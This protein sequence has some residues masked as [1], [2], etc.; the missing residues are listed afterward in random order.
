LLVPAI[1]ASQFAQPFMVSGVAVALPSLGA[2]LGAGATALSLVETLFLASSVALLLPAGRLGDTADKV[3]IYK[4]GLAGF[5]L[6]SIAVGLVSSVAAVLVLR[7]VQGIFAAAIQATGGAIIADAV[8]PE[9]RGRAYGLVIGSVYAGLTLGPMVAGLLVDLWGW[10]AVFIGG[11]LASILLFVPTHLLMKIHWRRPAPGAVHLPSAALAVLAMV[12]LVGGASSLRDGALAYVAVAAGLALCA[13]FVWWQRG[14]EQPLLNVQLVMAN[15]P[16]RNALLVQWLIYCN[17]FGAVFLLSLHMQTV[18]HA[19]ANASG[20]VLALGSLLMAVI[21]PFSGRLSDRV[22]PAMIAAVGVG[23][24][25]V[26][27]LM[28]TRL[29]SDSPLLYVGL[30]LAVQG[31]GFA[32]FSSPNMTIVMNS[33]PP[34]RTGIASA[35]TAAA[36][37]LGMVSGMLIVAAIISLQIGH[38]P[39]GAEPAKFVATMHLSFWIIAA[40]SAVAL[41]LSVMRSR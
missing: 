40:V 30:V 1:A 13:V 39:V 29:S 3:T 10:R 28:G 17:A 36:R 2:D 9:R 25:L 31:V 32:F 34:N 33:V 7:F 41:V 26:S 11:G 5:A 23:I 35:L 20:I 16:L 37:S 4:A 38:A 19:S 18:L 24:I 14:L 22:R 27:A 8:P 12:V 6:T 15:V 21:A